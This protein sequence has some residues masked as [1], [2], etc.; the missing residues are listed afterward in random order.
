LDHVLAIKEGSEMRQI[1]KC[2]RGNPA[3]IWDDNKPYICDQCQKIERLANHIEELEAEREREIEGLESEVEDVQRLRSV[4]EKTVLAVNAVLHRREVSDFYLANQIVFKAKIIREQR[5][6]ATARVAE[7][8][9][10]RD[11]L[12]EQIEG[13]RHVLAN[14]PVTRE[15][16]NVCGCALCE[17][18]RHLIKCDDEG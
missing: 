8:E 12:K 5:D 11:A 7:L 18:V 1:C 3:T 4:A 9:A 15:D 2:G 17:R 13:Y 14:I 16:L 10:E 6:D